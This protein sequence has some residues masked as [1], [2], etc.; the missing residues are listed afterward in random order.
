MPDT[1][2]R[3]RVRTENLLPKFISPKNPFAHPAPKPAAPAQADCAASA[4]ME[5]APLFAAENARAGAAPE[6]DLSMARRGQP[7]KVEIHRAEA[8]RTA[9][10]RPMPAQAPCAE[11][12]RPASCPPASAP[13]VTP[14]SPQPAQSVSSRVL[15]RLQQWTSWR[16][17]LR[18]KQPAVGLRLEVKTPPAPARVPN[19][20]AHAEMKAPQLTLGSQPLKPAGK[21]RSWF[22]W[23]KKLNP[24]ALLSGRRG[25]N[26]ASRGRAGKNHVQAELSLERVQVV[27]ND[28]READL[29]IVPGRLM[30][31]PSGA[32]PV[33]S[34][35][36]R[37]DTSGWSRLATHLLGVEHTHI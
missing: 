32:S 3:Y 7:V 17:A 9:E 12:V 13:P 33:L 24:L 10:H 6:T 35:A 8:K 25:G 29:E 31:M 16:P 34:K 20:T 21:S 23:I 1:D 2:C 19:G 36:A 18:S 15:A 27:R 26:M 30:G 5:T 4:R 11:A 37:P 14:A 28:L 22:G